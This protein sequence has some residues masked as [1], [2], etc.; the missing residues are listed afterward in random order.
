MLTADLIRAVCP[1]AHPEYVQ[2]FA[3]DKAREIFIAHGLSS[4]RVMAAMMANVDHE[5]GGLTIVRE[6]MKYSESAARKAFG[7]TT[8][9]RV[10]VAI[11]T[12]K[13]KAAAERER[14]IANAAYG[15]RLG[16]ED[17][18]ENDD[19]GYRYRGG[20]PLQS[21]G[22]SN[23]RALEKLTGVAFGSHPELIEV[24]EYWPLIAALTFTQHPSAG[25]L[26]PFAEQ[27]NFVA[28][29]AGINTGSPFAKIK[30]NGLADR[31][32]R[33]TAWCA[34]LGVLPA[35]SEKIYQ[36]G[37]PPSGAVKAIQHRLNELRYAEGRLSPDG[38][39]GQRTRSAVM[40]FQLENNLAANG[41]VDPATWA[42]LFGESAKPFPPPAAVLLGVEGMR[43]AGDPEIAQ[44][45][46]DKRMAQAASATG[47]VMLA[48]QTGLLDTLGTMARD[49]TTLQGT[50]TTLIGGLKFAATNLAAVALFFIA[51]IAWSKY[52]AVI[53]EKIGKWMRPVGA[54]K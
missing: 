26:A 16:N 24:P 47:A 53:S 7:P 40:D 25:N 13:G 42:A 6:N 3:S 34:A 36:F 8:L 31:Q 4:P 21:T 15:Y 19:D 49:L 12:G 51:A 37:A 32:N 23:Y 1:N 48:N 10:L 27:G 50:A 14:L 2:A 18:G 46:K 35:V 5:T 9:A 28:C 41:V 17:D 45:D 52:G 11:G 39:F 33:H 30:I 44:A 43:A 38:A 29:C 22:K 20:G 54:P